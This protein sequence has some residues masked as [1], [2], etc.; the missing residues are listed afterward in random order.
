MLG[1]IILVIMKK[2]LGLL[3]VFFLLGIFGAQ[4]S[5]AAETTQQNQLYVANT[6][7]LAT[8]LVFSTIPLIYQDPTP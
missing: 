4:G 5:V 6:D 1:V 2:R 7:A 3:M 8:T